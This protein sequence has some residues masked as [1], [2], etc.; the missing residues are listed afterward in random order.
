MNKFILLIS[1]MF[2]FC[3]Q[4]SNA[5]TITYSEVEK[6]DNKN[7]AFEI[8]GRFGQ[9][10]LIYKNINRRQDLTIYNNDMT[11]KEIIKLDFINDR[12]S[13]ID[14]VTYPDHFLMIWQYQKNNTI[15]CKAANMDSTGKLIGTVNDLDTTKS[16]VFGTL[17]S[18]DVT[19][20]ED[21][22]KILVYKSFYKN[23]EYTL[24][25]KII[26]DKINR[27][28][29]IR[30]II[31]YNDRR[32]AFSDLQIDNDG[33][34]FFSKE[35]QNARPEY[36][37]ALE[38]NFRKMHS[39]DFTVTQI[40]LDDQLI[41]D[42]RLKVD[43]LNKNYIINSFSY[44]KNNGSVGGI[45]TALISSDSFKLIKKALNIF[46][47]SLRTK[48]SGKTD[49]RTAFDNFFMKNIILK[50]DGGFIIAAEEY[51]K[52]RRFGNSYDYRY[53]PYSPY[54]GYN[55]YNRYYSSPSDYYLYNRDY[56]GYYR[57][58]GGNNNDRDVVYN[59][60]DIITFS[61]TKDLKLQW[62]SVINKTTSDIETDNFL[63]FSNMN[64]GGEIHF[65]FLQKDN[66]K[67]IISNHALQ[68]N[69]DI[70]RYATLKSRET[71]YLFMPRLARQTG[72][73]QMIIPCIVRNNIA[74]AKI[75][76]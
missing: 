21:K 17:P 13:N 76:F 53:N 50:K 75:D 71:G 23:D 63:S 73:R 38:I 60:D 18:Y 41:E 1:T 69:G 66:N 4:S 2:I 55:S 67:Q 28:D 59:Y 70:V 42:I 46:D 10:F 39:Y 29:S 44:R 64:A 40:P 65:L 12:T 9:N 16:G 49:Y 11:I 33:T 34:F 5:Q 58:Y 52:Q 32:E 48:L 22:R 68:P 24:A 19:W 26:D 62:N 72:A 6:S 3:A 7:A 43:N 74:F 25:A 15:Y 51:Y 47:D 14:F 35:K 45:F 20:S 57:P 31:S 30:T 27:L 8:L 36:I 61:F 37:N 54:G 56:Y